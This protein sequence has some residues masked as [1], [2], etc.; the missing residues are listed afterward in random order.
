VV[1]M[2]LATYA[3]APTNLRNENIGGPAS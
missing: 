2:A 3:A 1:A